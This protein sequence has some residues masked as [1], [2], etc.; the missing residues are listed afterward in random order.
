MMTKYHIQQGQNIIE[1]YTIV[2]RVF[3]I[4]GTRFE[5]VESTITGRGPLD[6]KHV[7]RGPGGR[8]EITHKELINVWLKSK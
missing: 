8:K 3:F 6:A 2:D 1:Y 7:I 4:R 5:V